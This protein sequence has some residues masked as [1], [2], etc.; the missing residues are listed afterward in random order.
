MSNRLGRLI[1]QSRDQNSYMNFSLSRNR[2][3]FTSHGRQWRVAP[4][5]SWL[6]P[7]APKLHCSDFGGSKIV[8]SAE[9]KPNQ[10]QFSAKQWTLNCEIPPV[11]VQTTTSPHFLLTTV[12]ISNRGKRDVF[13]V[14][15]GGE[16]TIER[17]EIRD[18]IY[19]RDSDVDAELI[20]CDSQFFFSASP[21]SYSHLSAPRHVQQP[22]LRNCIWA[23]SQ[24][25][26]KEAAM[27][28]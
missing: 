9:R 3:I 17:R 4:D 1:P 5:E 14:A 21:S 24:E 2:Y 6:S 25:R 22:E 15:S 19:G 16:R 11:R 23:L 8:D 7:S 12:H 28:L 27:M 13:A 18:E 10:L 20:I 26:R